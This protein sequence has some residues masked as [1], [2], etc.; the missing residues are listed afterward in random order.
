MSGFLRTRVLA[1]GCAALGVGA[2]LLAAPAL[3]ATP[4]ISVSPSTGLA[5]GQTVTVSLSG[6]SAGAPVAVIECSP[7]QATAQQ[8]ACDT[9]GVKIVTANA[10]GTATT[11]FTVT[12]GQI[13]TA[14]G[15]TC[16]GQGGVCLI[17]AANTG[18]QTQNATAQ[19]AFT[20]A[21]T[22]TPA[23]ATTAPSTTTL[24]RTGEPLKAM[25]MVGAVLVVVG[26]GLFAV[27]VVRRSRSGSYR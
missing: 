20:V 1:V 25:A 21:S 18:N 10:S 8:A 14:A 13:G 11:P 2:L 9:A 24:P 12:T 6:F 27:T 23:P 26:V 19:V 7:L 22:A 5:N 15:S 16:P 4:G 3:A 17:T